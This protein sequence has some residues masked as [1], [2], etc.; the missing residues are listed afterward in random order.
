M[1]KINTLFIL[2]IFLMTIPLALANEVVIDSS[3][4][5]TTPCSYDVRVFGQ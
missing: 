4:S 2:S 3:L 1:N 5:V